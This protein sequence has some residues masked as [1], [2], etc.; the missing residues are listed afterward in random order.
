VQRTVECFEQLPQ[1]HDLDP[2][3]DAGSSHELRSAYGHFR[4]VGVGKNA[5]TAKLR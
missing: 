5:N 1:R 2:R 3:L 4:M